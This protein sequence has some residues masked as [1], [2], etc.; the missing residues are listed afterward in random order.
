MNYIIMGLLFGIGWYL[1]GLIIQ[2]IEIPI[3]SRLQKA[4]W[5]Q[6]AAGTRLRNSNNTMEVGRITNKIGF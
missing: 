1:V 2:I 3:M 4:K 5:Y 6:V